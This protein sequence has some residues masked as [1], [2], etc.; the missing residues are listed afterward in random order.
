LPIVDCRLP[1]LVRS[2]FDKSAIGNRQSKMFYLNRSPILVRSIGWQ[3]AIGNWQSAIENALCLNRL[4]ILVRSIGWQSA[5]G[6][7]KC[8]MSEPIADFGSVVV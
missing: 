4:P 5:I 2:S 1:I 7:R 3:S 8:S 6:N